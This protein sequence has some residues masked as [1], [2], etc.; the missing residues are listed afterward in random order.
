GRDAEACDLPLC[1]GDGRQAR[2]GCDG[3]SA[4]Q[5]AGRGVLMDAVTLKTVN[6][7][8]RARRAVGLVTD[9]DDGSG[10][11]VHEG[12]ELAGELGEAV[13]DAFRSGKSGVVEA[14]GRSFFLNGHLPYARLVI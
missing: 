9:L 1:G 13:K 4:A 2:G 14:G 8:R 6:A 12:D 11:I 3:A 7:G 5:E 10:R